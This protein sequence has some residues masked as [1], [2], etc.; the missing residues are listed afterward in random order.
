ME[1]ET[2]PRISRPVTAAEAAAAALRLEKACAKHVENYLKSADRRVLEEIRTYAQ[3]HEKRD[4][5]I[6]LVRSALTVRAEATN[7]RVLEF[8][9]RLSAVESA[10]DRERAMRK[11][12]E[13]R[14][15]DAIAANRKSLVERMTALV[16][17]SEKDRETSARMEEALMNMTQDLCRKM[18][19]TLR[20]EQRARGALESKVTA[21]VHQVCQRVESGLGGGFGAHGTGES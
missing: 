16:T 19:E 6:E 15:S 11:D 14:F 13:A 20:R 1:E 5:K 3:I 4:E 10:L 17:R 7:G 21:L 8:E 12:A 9:R 18:N 2:P